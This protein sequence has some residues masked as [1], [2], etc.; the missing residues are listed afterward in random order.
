MMLYRW[1]VYAELPGGNRVEV[2][3]SGRSFNGF[4]ECEDHLFSNATMDD[5]TI[6]DCTAKL[7]TEIQQMN[8][9]YRLCWN[10]CKKKKPKWCCFC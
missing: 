6:P 9:A 2:M 3:R 4:S 1:V 5:L 10:V 8:T 7:T